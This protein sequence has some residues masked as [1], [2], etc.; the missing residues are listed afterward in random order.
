MVTDNTF[1]MNMDHV[2]TKNKPLDLQTPEDKEAIILEDKINQLGLSR[3]DE[4]KD[5][6]HKVILPG[7]YLGVCLRSEISSLIRRLQRGEGDNVNILIPLSCVKTEYQE[8][9]HNEV[10]TI[11]A[12]FSQKDPRNLS[13]IESLRQSNMNYRVYDPLGHIISEETLNNSG[14]TQIII[15]IFNTKEEVIEYVQENHS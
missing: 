6:T 10:D 14:K 4:F 11:E 15:N 9:G 5:S 12:Y 8:D 1:F 2:Y 13:I 7:R 3:P